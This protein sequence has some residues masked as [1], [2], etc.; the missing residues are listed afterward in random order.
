M[1][2]FAFSVYDMDANSYVYYEGAGQL[3]TVA[4]LSK[5]FAIDYALSRV[6]LDDVFEAN[7][8]TLK[9]VLLAHR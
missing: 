2:P 3:P 4:S 9:L 1:T 8:E 6:K 5:L 7:E